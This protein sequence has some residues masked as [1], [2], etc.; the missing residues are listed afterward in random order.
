MGWR[1]RCAAGLAAW[2]IPA[3]GFGQVEVR[4]ADEAD[5]AAAK[6]LPPSDFGEDVSGAPLPPPETAQPP[7]L[8]APG[9]RFETED[10]WGL[11]ETPL[12]LAPAGTAQSE[13][14][15]SGD[16]WKRE[17][18]PWPSERR[19][20]RWDFAEPYS[21][22]SATPDLGFMS[23]TLVGDVDDATHF[24]E[25]LEAEL[26]LLRVGVNALESVNSDRNTDPNLDLDLRLP[27][28]LGEW[29]Y[30]SFLPGVSFPI[31]DERKRTPETT[32]VR[33]QA[34]WGFGMGGVGLQARAGVT[35]GFR[36]AGLL[37][38]D[39]TLTRTA[40]LWGGLVAWRLVPWLQLRAEASGEIAMRDDDPDRLTLLPGVAFYPLADARVEI[41]TVVLI[42]EVSDGLDF[43]DPALGGL[44][45]LGIW[46]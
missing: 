12:V 27:I 6:E 28:P 39:R 38:V 43:D 33:V 37:D 17:P 13:E 15:L 16:L 41:G 23:R 40:G 14:I 44:F 26:Y 30:L 19:V 25:R 24:V 22:P 29:Q 46:F 31:D 18:P 3:A 9:P 32:N 35:D 21:F 4:E 45:N 42:E 36:R 5:R 1:L 20:D 7:A 2:M 8:A 10:G 11:I 34:V